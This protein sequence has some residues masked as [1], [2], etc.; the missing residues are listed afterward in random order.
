[1]NSFKNK[2]AQ[3]IITPLVILFLQATVQAQPVVVPGFMAIES[4]LL[5]A[6][7]PGSHS[8][9]AYFT[10]SNL[11][12]EPIVLLGASS[13]IFESA[14]LNA[15]GHEAIESIVIQ[16][17]ERLIME[18]DGFHVHLDEIDS[19]L[20]SGQSQEVT[21]LVRRGLEALE[22]VEAQERN[23]NSGI[24]ARRAG[25]PNEHDIV[26]RVPVRN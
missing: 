24:R 3:I 13:E 14:S 11:H 18:S 7:E 22:E 8:T 12:S 4:S 16:P 20:A 15:P 23:A 21:L 9:L 2:I 25:V 10:I 17:R 1:M 6:P 26:V 19:S 5:E